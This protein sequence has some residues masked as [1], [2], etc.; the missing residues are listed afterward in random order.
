M[1]PRR[2][3]P[4]RKR[5][6]R[7]GGQRKCRRTRGSTIA[8][9]LLH[10]EAA[11]VDAEVVLR[12]AE[13][14]AVEV[15]P[16]VG[17]PVGVRAADPLDRLRPRR[18]RSAPSRGVRGTAS[19][20]WTSRWK[21]SGC[22]CSTHCAPWPTITAGPSSAA[23]PR[24]RAAPRAPPSRPRAEA[25]S[26]SRASPGT[27]RPG[28]GRAARRSCRRARRTTRPAPARPSAP[29]RCARPARGR[30]AASRAARPASSRCAPPPAP[31][32]RATVRIGIVVPGL[33]G[34]RAQQDNTGTR[35]REGA[36]GRGGEGA[37]GRGGGG[38]GARG[39]GGEGARGRGGGGA[40]GR[41]GPA[42]YPLPATRYPLPA[43]RYPLPATYR[44]SPIAYRLSPFQPFSLRPD[45]FPPQLR[46]A[47]ASLHYTGPR[48]RPNLPHRTDPWKLPRRPA[49][50]STW[51]TATR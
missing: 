10:A 3:E 15:L 41:R 17:A 5:P 23:A 20:A 29:P 42:Y 25:R 43:T 16:D 11:G 7:H 18:R 12:R 47:A 36:R 1:W 9:R 33:P 44:L 50:A 4:R 13:P 48:D 46:R 8:S 14:L 22:A 24:S 31:S 19:G 39:R 30:A 21:A 2:S 37:R 32:C 35:G 51:S 45:P 27:P 6:V 38:E 34:L 40:N 26:A 49:R 28:T